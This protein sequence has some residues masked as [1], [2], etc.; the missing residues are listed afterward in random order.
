MQTNSVFYKNLFPGF[1][2]ILLVTHMVSLYVDLIK[3]DGLGIFHPVFYWRNMK[4]TFDI[5]P[6]AF[7]SLEMLWSQLRQER[8]DYKMT[9]QLIV[10]L[11]IIDYANKH[12][13]KGS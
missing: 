10:S 5:T 4:V 7:R 3:R 11:A 6:E 1:V 2:V 9:R 8:G 13:G 12:N